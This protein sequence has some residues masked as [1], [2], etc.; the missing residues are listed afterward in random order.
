LYASLSLAHRTGD[1]LVRGA[2]AFDPEYGSLLVGGTDTDG[3]RK[4]VTELAL[5]YGPG[6]IEVEQPG[7]VGPGEEQQTSA[8]GLA[9]QAGVVWVPTRRVGLGLTGVGNF[10]ELRMFAA[11]TLSLHVGSVR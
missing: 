8:L 1:Y 5:L 4:E 11:L 7:P 3:W 2:A 9:A 6:Y 10:N